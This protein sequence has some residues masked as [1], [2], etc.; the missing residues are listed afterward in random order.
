MYKSV[1]ADVIVVMAVSGT[2][3][4]KSGREFS[5]ISAFILEWM[6]RS[7]DSS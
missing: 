5:E 2:K 1:V 3:T 7:R 4:S 6:L